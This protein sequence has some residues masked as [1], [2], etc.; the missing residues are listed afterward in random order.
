MITT[1]TLNAAVDKTYVVPGFYKS[2]LFRVNE[3]VADPGG[4]GIN[5][6]RVVTLL[7]GKAIAT[8]FIAGS[9]GAFIQKGLTRQGVSH[10]FI[11][12]H[13]GESR[14]CTTI[15]DPESDEHQTELLEMGPTITE[16]D[17]IKL[18]H[19][20][21][22]LAKQSS[23]VAMSGSLPVGCPPTIYADLIQIVKEHGAKA[24]L[25]A[26]GDALAA[27]VEA[28][29]YLIKPNEH[30]IARLTGKKHAS[31]DELAHAIQTLMDQG[32][33]CVI[34]SLGKRGALAGWEG[35]IYRAQAPVIDAVNPVGSGD[36]M[37][38]GMITAI[39]CGATAEEALRLGVAS[40]AA[41]ALNLRAGFVDS[42]VVEQLKDEVLIELYVKH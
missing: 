3:M 11:E 8:G 42:Q 39:E 14:L 41:N 35:V 10:D 5:V 1:L 36:S 2:G 27:G 30:E 12:A 34:V 22:E 33:P 21:A 31:D 18:K 25:D 17:I 4:K 24:I 28:K 23:I 32:I 19:K 13:E 6:A 15:L 16:D 9:Q 20:V 29:P 7:G 37:V 40:G 38:A 26:S